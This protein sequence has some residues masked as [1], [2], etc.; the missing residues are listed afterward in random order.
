MTC[1]TPLHA[2]T[3]IRNG[4]L[5]NDAFVRIGVRELRWLLRDAET[6]NKLITRVHS[7]D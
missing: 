7:Q 1:E 5:E 3:I 4:I 6:L 2:I